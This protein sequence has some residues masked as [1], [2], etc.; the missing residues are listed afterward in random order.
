MITLIGVGHVFAI[1]ENVKEL[2]RSRRPEVVCLELD[3]ARFNALMH[4]NSHRSVPL[5]YR[6]LAYFQTRTAEK[7]GTEIGGEM[8]AAASAAGE[9]GAKIALIDLDAARVFA[10]LWRKMSFREKMNLL[11]GAAIGLFMP[12]KTVE[13]EM[14]KYEGNEAQYLETLGQGF[15]AVKEVLIDDR[16][17]HMVEQLKAIAS[18]HSNIVAV[19]GD[20]HI[21]GIVE[22]LKPL[23]TEVV[24]LRDIRSGAVQTPASGAEYS[25][26]FWY[27][28]E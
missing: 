8:L 11:G 2:I 3:P 1:S 26:T 22:S 21:P 14:D 23:E 16:N 19:V 20:G 9:I 6:L 5:Q 15:P 25:T 4:K 13:R 18:Q 7:F 28:N 24:R 17:K 10:Q 12:K 27:H